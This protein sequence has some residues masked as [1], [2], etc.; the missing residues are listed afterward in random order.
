MEARG[1]GEDCAILT[2]YDVQGTVRRGFATRT[3]CNL[4]HVNTSSRSRDIWRGVLQLAKKCDFP[5]ISP[6]SARI[7][8]RKV[9]SGSYKSH[10]SGGPL[11]EK[12]R[13]EV[14]LLQLN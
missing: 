4:R 8:G 2:D 9:S 11:G 6:S 5:N 1:G 13:P 12:F 7:N 3:R 14:V 10:L